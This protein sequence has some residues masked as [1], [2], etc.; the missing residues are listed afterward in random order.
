M[1][2]ANFKKYVSAVVAAFIA[3][4][5]IMPLSALAQNA[6]S[7]QRGFCARISEQSPRIDQR[8]ADR[9]LKLEAKR[10]E[11]LINLERRQSERDARFI[12]N[13]AKWDA[14]RQEHYAKLEEKAATDKNSIPAAIEK[15]KSSCAS[16]TTQPAIRE[17]FLADME[18]AHAKFQ[19]DREAVE[20]LKNSIDQLR[21]NRKT[22]I[23]K[24]A[25]DFKVAAEKARTDLKT[26]LQT[27]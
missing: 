12:A 24:A 13:R 14:N 17:A 2:Q 27:Q 9:L 19:S 16:G 3:V 11:R 8:I 25:D 4:N 22:A 26:A 1:K 21:E 10:A 23:D 5:A 15:A 6:T 18:S 20:K 7:T